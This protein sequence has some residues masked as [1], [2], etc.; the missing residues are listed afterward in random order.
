MPDLRHAP[1]EAGSAGGAPETALVEPMSPVGLVGVR[2]D[3]SD[4]T[5][6]K[7]LEV[8]SGLPLPGVRQAALRHEDG[9][10]WYWMAPDE[11]LLRVPPDHSVTAV[12]ALES[13]LSGMHSLVADLS[14]SR[15][16]FRISGPTA[17]EVLAKGAPVDLHPEAFRRGMFRRTHVAGIAAAF[18]LVSEDPDTFELFCSRSYARYMRDWLVNAAR[19]GAVVGIYAPSKREEPGSGTPSSKRTSSSAT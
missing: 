9:S 1:P 18:S 8:E 7:A 10:G 6:R 12:N 11:L 4:A 14:D 13:A 16:F 19:P 17:R 2:A 5:L 15:A 3:L